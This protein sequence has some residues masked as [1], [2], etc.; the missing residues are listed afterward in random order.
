MAPVYYRVTKYDMLWLRPENLRLSGR[1]CVVGLIDQPSWLGQPAYSENIDRVFQI[2]GT[3]CADQFDDRAAMHGA[4]VLSIITGR[5][6]VAPKARVVY[7]AI[8]TWHGRTSLLQNH[9]QALR[10]LKIHAESGNRLDAISTSHGWQRGEPGA[11]END[12]L[13]E[14]F[15]KCNVPVFSTNDRRMYPCGPHGLA[16]QWRALA[17]PPTIRTGQIAVPV[18]DRLIACRN[19]QEINSYGDLYYRITQG[20]A[21]WGAPFFAGLF[22]LAREAIPGITRSDFEETLLTTC[23]TI[24][25]DSTCKLPL[26]DMDKFARA[27]EPETPTYNSTSRLRS[28]FSKDR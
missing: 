2:N 14:W 7:C 6:G 18:D 4:A 3:R 23:R 20:G 19:R 17:S 25:F 16:M 9:A 5:L 28:L 10:Q 1:G 22:M 11:K 15:E 27:L 8:E 21:S 13:V 24:E 12:D 26:P